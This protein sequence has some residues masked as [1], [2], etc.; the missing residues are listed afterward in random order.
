MLTVMG[1]VR[2][3]VRLSNVQVDCARRRVVPNP[4]HPDVLVNK[5]K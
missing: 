3:K 4:A 1:E 5:L 2:I